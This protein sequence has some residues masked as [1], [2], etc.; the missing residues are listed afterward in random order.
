[1]NFPHYQVPWLG[2]GMVI[3]LNAVIHV[4]ISHG[5]AFGL[6]F[7]IALVELIGYGKKW[8]TWDHMAY[9]TLIPTVVIIT[10]VGAITGVGIWFTIGV[11]APRASASMLRIFFWPWFYEW[12]VFVAEAIIIVWYYLAWEKMG[13]TPGRKIGHI[14]LGF[15]YPALGFASAFLITG[16]IGFMLTPD[17]WPWDHDFYSAFFNESLWPQ[18]FLRFFGGIAMGALWMILLITFRTVDP[19]ARRGGVR[20]CGFLFVLFAIGTGMATWIY[21]ERI[22]STYLTH[23]LFSLLTSHLSQDPWIFYVVNIVGGV[24]L[25]LTA[26]VALIGWVVP[27]KVLV[28]PALLIAFGFTA[29]YERIREFIRGPFVMPGYMYASQVLLKEAPELNRVGS[30]SRS[31][32]YNAAYHGADSR[33]VGEALFGNN[34]TTCHTIGG[35]NDIRDRVRGRPEDAIFVILGHTNQLVPFMPPF[36]GTEAERKVLAHYLYEIT[37]RDVYGTPPSRYPERT[38]EDNHRD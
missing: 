2:N 28:V 11:L 13:L 21:F 34:C 36:A 10:S 8:G 33:N 23:Y 12:L 17:G 31:Y 14:A 3:G 38:G 35:L 24:V 26:L 15:A 16:I 5:L 19:E 37:E 7:V 22:P 27:S 25:V 30:L 20:L 1:M 32:W 4:I 9:H 29:E 18:T 6:V